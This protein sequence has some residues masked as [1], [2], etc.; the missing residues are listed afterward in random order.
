MGFGKVHC[1]LAFFKWRIKH[2]RASVT[3]QKIFEKMIGRL[4][5]ANTCLSNLI[6]P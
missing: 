4:Y 2:K 6:S 5:K 1:M 3:S